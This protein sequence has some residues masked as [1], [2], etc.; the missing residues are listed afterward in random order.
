MPNNY[1]DGM[2][3]RDFDRA[4]Q[5]ESQACPHGTWAPDCG[6]CADEEQAEAADRRMSELKER[7]PEYC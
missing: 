6:T 4:H 7:D 5:D 1:P 3:M 2:T